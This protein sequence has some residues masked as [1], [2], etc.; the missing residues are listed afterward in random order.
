MTFQSIN[1]KC[2]TIQGCVITHT[3]GK[4]INTNSKISRNTPRCI[5]QCLCFNKYLQYCQCLICKGRGAG[6]QA[7][8]IILFLRAAHSKSWHVYLKKYCTSVTSLQITYS[9]T[10]TKYYDKKY[11]HEIQD[12]FSKLEHSTVA[13]SDQ[14]NMPSQPL[15]Q[16]Q[17][18]SDGRLQAL[19]LSCPTTVKC[20]NTTYITV[21]PYWKLIGC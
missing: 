5:M 6:A 13:R 9:T 17:P 2:K 21:M 19:K 10:Y 11:C 3:K 15:K 8:T 18:T 1:T 7:M 14:K 12:H 4:L 16:A 20:C